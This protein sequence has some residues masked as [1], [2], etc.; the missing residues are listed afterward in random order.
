[1]KSIVIEKPGGYRRLKIKE[2]AEPTP[3]KN[4][5]L[6]EVSA[7][8]INFADIFIRLGLYKSAKE[9]VGWPVTPSAR[10]SA[11]CAAFGTP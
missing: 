2:S 5:V 6:V 3:E 4:E 11:I 9:F 10:T 1:M 8:G 7:A